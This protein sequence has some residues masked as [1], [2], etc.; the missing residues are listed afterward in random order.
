VISAICRASDVL[1][2]PSD[3]EPWALVI[4]EAAAAGQAIVASQVVGA[5]AELVRDG[6]NGR[7]FPTGDLKALVATLFE[8]TAPNRIDAMRANSAAILADWRA[9]ADPI[10]GLRA[11]L[12]FVKVI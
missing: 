11:A 5:A 1:C 10:D 3:Y 7:V 2:L 12:K 6:L 8:V 9:R 4:N